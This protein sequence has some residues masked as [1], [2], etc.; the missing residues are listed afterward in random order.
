MEI[1][2]GR[3]TGSG[4]Y[5]ERIPKTCVTEATSSA[6]QSLMDKYGMSKSAA[7]RHL[8]DN[9]LVYMAIFGDGVSEDE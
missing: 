1:K 7:I 6:I 2:R 3:A 4:V 5:S 8:L 9:G